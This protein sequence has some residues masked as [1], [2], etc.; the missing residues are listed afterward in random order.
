VAVQKR[1]KDT[2]KSNS[3]VEVD[4]EVQIISVRR[5]I[6]CT[7]FVDIYADDER[8]IVRTQVLT[9]LLLRLNKQ[10][11][12]NDWRAYATVGADEEEEQC[13][14]NQRFVHFVHFYCKIIKVR[15]VNFKFETLLEVIVGKTN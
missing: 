11:D 3:T 12:A 1:C 8:S 6:N 15:L 13:I 9:D 4:T 7:D 14:G 2:K 5:V 10:C